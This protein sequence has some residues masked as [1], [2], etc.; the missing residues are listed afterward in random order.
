MK[1]LANRIYAFRQRNIRCGRK[2]AYAEWRC[3]SAMLALTILIPPAIAGDSI[4][5]MTSI[6]DLR[7]RVMTSNCPKEFVELWNKDYSLVQRNIKTYEDSVASY[8]KLK[9]E[10]LSDE[11]WWGGSAWSTNTK[12]LSDGLTAIKISAE[13]FLSFTGA[14]AAKSST[15]AAYALYQVQD[16]G[17]DIWEINQ[18]YANRSQSGLAYKTATSASELYPTNIAFVADGAK[19]ILSLVANIDEA[20]DNSNAYDG[21]RDELIRGLDRFDQ[22]IADASKKLFDRQWA[23]YEKTITGIEKACGKKDD[24]SLEDALKALVD[25]QLEVA[26]GQR[27]ALAD[28]PDIQS[29]LNELNA[30]AEEAKNA[31]PTANSDIGIALSAILNAAAAS[32]ALNGDSKT[33]DTSDNKTPEYKVE[34]YDVDNIAINEFPAR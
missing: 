29:S 27:Q 12:M 30:A 24:D 28:S 22:N 31:S 26:D 33:E 34:K 8:Q 5:P 32:G 3:L 9:G 15:T 25:D 2:S 11:T 4:A 17:K 16:K 18:Y 6:T 23:F 7:Q 10:T 20:I 21:Y 1:P 14:A 19:T 13:L